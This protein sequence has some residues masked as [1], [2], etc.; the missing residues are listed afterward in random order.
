MQNPGLIFTEIER[1]WVYIR[2]LND[3]IS[4]LTSMMEYYSDSERWKDMLLEFQNEYRDDMQEFEKRIIKLE[5]RPICKCEDNPWKPEEEDKN[6]EEEEPIEEEEDID[7]AEIEAK[8]T[9]K[10]GEVMITGEITNYDEDKVECDIAF[11]DGAII[12][13]QSRFIYEGKNL[14]VAGGTVEMQAIENAMLSNALK[15]VSKVMYTTRD[16]VI[17]NV[18]MIDGPII[19]VTGKYEGGKLNMTT[20]INEPYNGKL[21]GSITF[22]DNITD[23]TFTYDKKEYK[24]PGTYSQTEWTKGKPSGAVTLHITNEPY[25]EYEGDYYKDG[26]EV[27]VTLTVKWYISGDAPDEPEVEEEDKKE[28]EEDHYEIGPPPTPTVYHLTV[29][30]SNWGLTPIIIDD[31]TEDTTLMVKVIV[32]LKQFKPPPEPEVPPVVEEEEDKK[33][34]YDIIIDF[35]GGELWEDGKGGNVIV[36]HPFGDGTL[37]GTILFSYTGI[38]GGTTLTHNGIKY[39]VL[40]GNLTRFGDIP[41]FPHTLHLGEGPDFPYIEQNNI[42]FDGLLDGTFHTSVEKKEQEEEDK[43]EELEFRLSGT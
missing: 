22:G 5:N 15:V 11:S 33:E 18:E 32:N 31:Y 14:I 25:L 7:E 9:F 20:T 10:N 38:D 43:Y 1:I 13:S 19:H 37:E 23:G 28:E 40:G 3:R 24:V 16:T 39:L 8:I 35:S 34:V 41:G 21:K 26:D 27:D 4:E 30:N 36:S 12:P 17:T 42:P 29:K 2:N 6:E